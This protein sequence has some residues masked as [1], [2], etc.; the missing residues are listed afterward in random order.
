MS[1]RAVFSITD[2][3]ARATF[4]GKALVGLKDIFVANTWSVSNTN[5]GGRIAF[6]RAGFL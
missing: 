1:G 4:D 2:Y 5:Y 6:D 3:I